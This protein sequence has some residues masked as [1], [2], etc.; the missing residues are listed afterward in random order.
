MEMVIAWLVMGGLATWLCYR[1]DKCLTQIEQLQIQEQ[2]LRGYVADLE[3]TIDEMN[4]P[5]I[6]EFDD[7]DFDNLNE[8][9]KTNSG[10]DFYRRAGFEWALAEHDAELSKQVLEQIWDHKRRRNALK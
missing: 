1:W 10:R 7:D 8:T 9:L 6:K 2:A 5:Y 3:D 4:Q